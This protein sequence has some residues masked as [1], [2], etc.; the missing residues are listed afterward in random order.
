MSLR[1]K[2]KIILKPIR[3][4]NHEDGKLYYGEYK[5]SFDLLRI[6]SWLTL[7][8]GRLNNLLKFDNYLNL[9]L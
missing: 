7:H 8:P 3:F 5:G 1:D 2:L 9:T 6:I 4:Y